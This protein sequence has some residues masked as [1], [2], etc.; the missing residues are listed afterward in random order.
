VLEAVPTQG[1]GVGEV[2]ELTGDDGVGI[3]VVPESLNT[4]TQSPL[5]LWERAGVRVFTPGLLT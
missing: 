2:A 5:S 4:P 3:D 1:L